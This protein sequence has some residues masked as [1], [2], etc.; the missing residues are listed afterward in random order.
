MDEMDIVRKI[1]KLFYDFRKQDGFFP[2]KEQGDMKHREIMMLD[3]IMKMNQSNDLVKMSEISSSLGITPAAVSQYIKN[4]ERNGWVER[5]VLENDRRSVYIKVT[6][7]AK[8]MIKYNET[9]MIET[10][11]GFIEV[12]GKDDAE[13]LVRILEKSATYFSTHKHGSCKKGDQT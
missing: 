9:H 11:V 5:I 2:H 3:T 12:L 1:T 4:F 8:E 10:L 6:P 7:S 13:A